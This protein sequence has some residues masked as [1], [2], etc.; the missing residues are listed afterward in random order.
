MKYFYLKMTWSAVKDNEWWVSFQLNKI[1][2]HGAIHLHL[3]V[4]QKNQQLKVLFLS[5]WGTVFYYLKDNVSSRWA[6]K[7]PLAVG[8][9]RIS[10]IAIASV[11]R[12]FHLATVQLV[13]VLDTLLTIN[14]ITS[15]S[16]IVLPITEI[17]LID[18]LT[19]ATVSASP[20]TSLNL[21][22][23][24]QQCLTAGQLPIL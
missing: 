1:K 20:G 18:T 6:F 4:D 3:T 10:S 23:E 24:W 22:H 14:F 7:S 15:I 11:S 17:I 8:K 12:T 13:H 19:I 21:A 16:T 9:L 5:F 2:D